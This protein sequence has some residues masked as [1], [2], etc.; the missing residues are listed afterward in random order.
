MKTS[1]DLLDGYTRFVFMKVV[2]LFVQHE[3]FGEKTDLTTLDIQVF[4]PKDELDREYFEFDGG[5]MFSWSTKNL[6]EENKESLHKMI[7]ENLIKGNLLPRQKLPSFYHNLILAEA[8]KGN[9]NSCI[10]KY[11]E[12]TE[13]D[14]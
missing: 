13:S 7:A 11:V 12:L 5:N 3:A 10:T 8:I 2:A 9:R 1:D 14:D 6:S 4:S